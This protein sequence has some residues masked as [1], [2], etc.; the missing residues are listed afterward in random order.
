MNNSGTDIT[1]QFLNHYLFLYN[2]VFY[3]VESLETKSIRI[4]SVPFFQVYLDVK[5]ASDP[6]VKFPIVILGAPKA[7]T[8]PPYPTASASYPTAA[9]GF[10][11]TDLPPPAAPNLFDPPPSYGTHYLY[12][13]IAVFG[14]NH[15]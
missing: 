12:P 1:Y 9:F 5:Y 7:S 4:K 6:E 14:N 8:A 3:N 2:S 13:S 10:G 15:Q 11:N